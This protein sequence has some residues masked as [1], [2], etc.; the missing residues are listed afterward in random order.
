[1]ADFRRIRDVG[2]VVGLLAIPFFFLRANVKRADR[3]SAIDRGFLR[4]SAPLEYRASNL[5]RGISALW[6]DYVYLVDVKADR[7]RLSYENARLRDT[8]HKLETQVSETRDL[9]RLLQLRQSIPGESVTAE[10]VGKDFSPYFRVTRVILDRESRSVK[11][12]DPVVSPDGVVGR[13][14]SVSGDAVETQLAVDAAFLLDV[15][16]ERSHARGFVRGTGDPTRYAA[17]VEMVDAR[18]D[19]EVGDLLVTSGMGKLFPKGLPVARVSKVIK[20]ELGQNQEIE[21]VPTVD[22]GRLD[23]VLI[24]AGYQATRD[25]IPAKR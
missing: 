17:R 19:V 22:F 2:V 18:D 16:D 1:M 4:V 24:L 6:A 12:N 8:L 25:P 9:R 23:A 21:A 13:V 10:V 5:A 7:E 3:L 14:M 11:T 15:E 20:R